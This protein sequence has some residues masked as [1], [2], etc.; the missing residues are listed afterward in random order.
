MRMCEGALQ[1][2]VVFGRAQAK[3]YNPFNSC[4]NLPIVMHMEALMLSALTVLY[5]ALKAPNN[6]NDA[7]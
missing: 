3:E 1:G 4:R 7:G 2:E 5:I 6:Q